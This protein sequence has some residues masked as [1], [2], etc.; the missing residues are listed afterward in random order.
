[1]AKERSQRRLATILAADIVGYSRLMEEDE[2]ATLAALKERRATVIDPLI[3]AHHG[4]IVKLMGNGTL[5]EFASVLDA[6]QC[7]IAVQRG[8][9]RGQT[10][11]VARRHRL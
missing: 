5:A 2:S 11:T 6:V 7:A 9:G 10:S 4:R 8:T 3:A 1:M